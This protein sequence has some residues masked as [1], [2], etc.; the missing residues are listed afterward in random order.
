[1]LGSERLPCFKYPS[2]HRPVGAGGSEH[3]SIP[4][5]APQS[6]NICC[7]VILPAA[8]VSRQTAQ[9]QPATLTVTGK[10]AAPAKRQQT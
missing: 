9:C 2:P 1:M 3:L 8:V 10:G 5:M 4:L 7:L 6:T